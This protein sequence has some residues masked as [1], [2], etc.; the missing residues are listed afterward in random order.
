LEELDAGSDV[1]EEQRRRL[2][3]HLINEKKARLA[4]LLREGL[5][6]EEVYQELSV[7]LDEDLTR[8]QGERATSSP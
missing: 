5:L 7:K 4:S 8:L 2:Q 6:S 3:H 1:E